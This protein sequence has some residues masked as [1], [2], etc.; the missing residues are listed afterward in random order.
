MKRIFLL[1]LLAGCAVGPKYKQPETALP[2]TFEQ[3]KQTFEEVNISSWWKQFDD[4]YLELLIEEAIRD[5]YDMKL[6]AEKIRELR[7][8]YR[9]E[10]S[11]LY[12]SLQMNASANRSRRSPN[13]SEA[14]VDST[15]TSVD[16]FENFF[17]GPLFQNFFQVGLDASWELDLFGK[18]RRRSQAARQDM[19]AGIEQMHAVQVVLAADV[20]FSYLEIRTLQER[21]HL[22]KRRIERQQEL[23]KLSEAL[24]DAG[25]SSDI[26]VE[27]QRAQLE[28]LIQDV[29]T[30]EIAFKQ[31]IFFLATLLGKQPEGFARRFETITPIPYAED[32]LPASMPSEM[33]RR[34]PDLRRAERELAAA[35]SR[36]GVAVA[37]LFPSF[38]LLGSF[39]FQ[40]NKPNNLF[41]WA[42]R[43]WQVG[44][45][46]LWS[47]FEGGRLRAQVKIQTSLQKQA[48]LRYEQTVISSLE[49][50]ESSLAAYFEEQN[51]LKSIEQK[52]I[53]EE[54]LVKYATDRF[55]SGLTGAQEVLEAENVLTQTQQILIDSRQRLMMDLVA[56]YKALGG[57]W[58]YM[59]CESE[60]GA[61]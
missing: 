38:S 16:T 31:R 55:T 58:P 40:S 8:F 43:F 59:G 13:V 41:D 28:T 15:G 1:I 48:L 21:I 6:A 56:L 12:P 24:L 57:G 45:S 9:A 37:D 42:S 36:I 5:N 11:S 14:P 19:E 25:L 32:R 2:Q 54:L 18:N 46:M 61:K 17:S 26:D 52:Q 33:V 4:V 39:G 49:E 23:L 35:T 53:A 7:A 50:V 60:Y 51:R 3:Q 30:L 27:I 29:H 47:L 44:P 34:R 22:Q 10:S 20:A